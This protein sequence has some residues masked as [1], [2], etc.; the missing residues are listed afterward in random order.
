MR[1]WVRSKLCRNCTF[2]KSAPN[3]IVLCTVLI[4]LQHHSIRYSLKQILSK[5]WLWF[6]RLSERIWLITLTRNK[7]TLTWTHIIHNY[8]TYS[9]FT[10]HFQQN[11][12][13]LTNN[14]L[15]FSIS[16]F[17][18][19]QMLTKSIDTNKFQPNYFLAYFV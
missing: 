2:Y 6:R 3:Y 14:S 17:T 12:Q 1:S 4:P 13:H 18:T 7:F 16:D 9:K 11:H 5:Q 8:N 10:C 19:P 15:T